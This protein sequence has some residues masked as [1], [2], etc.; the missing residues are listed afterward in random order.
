MDS[1]LYLTY[2]E[3]FFQ[4][5]FNMLCAFFAAMIAYVLIEAPLRNLINGSTEGVDRRTAPAE[6]L[7]DVSLLKMRN[8][9]SFLKHQ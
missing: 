1:A 9:D 4:L 6:T 2:N 7:M 8:L 3:M 5:I